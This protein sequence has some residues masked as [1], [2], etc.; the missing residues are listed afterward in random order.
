MNVIIKTSII[1]VA[2]DTTRLQRLIT[3]ACL[4]SIQKYT[5]R[6]EYELI[7]IDQGIIKDLD[8]KH[9]IIDIDK[10]IKI[11]H[12]GCSAA[13]NLGYKNS[14]PNYGLIA[15]IHNDVFVYEGWLQQLRDSLTD[16]NHRIAMPHQG[17]TAREHVLNPIQG[18]DDAGLILMSKETFLE[19][20]GWDERIK[21][22]YPEYA[23]R[24]RFP[25]K[26][27]VVPRCI[28]THIGSVV[29]CIDDQMEKDAYQKESEL[30]NVLRDDEVMLKKNYL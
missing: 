24:L 26:Y 2:Y 15:F 19:T 5:N 14:N 17:K 4:A 16:H 18:N 11:A 3:S 29:A 7:F 22:I 9:H 30:V 8:K 13:M 20:G 27:H 23:F 10:H 1:V 21:M 25:C 28:I 12:I 6:D